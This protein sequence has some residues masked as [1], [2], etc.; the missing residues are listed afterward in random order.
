MRSSYAMIAGVLYT[1]AASLG[2]M[3]ENLLAFKLVPCCGDTRGLDEGA[4]PL[5]PTGS[6]RV[7]LLFWF[8]RLHMG[9]TRA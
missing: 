9:D 6:H 5:E 8:Y 7:A 2:T 1:D 4:G 3:I